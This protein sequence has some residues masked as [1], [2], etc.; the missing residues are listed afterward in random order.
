MSKRNYSVLVNFGMPW[1]IR[2]RLTT[3]KCRK[4]DK[5]GLPEYRG[6][7]YLPVFTGDKLKA[8]KIAQVLRVVNEL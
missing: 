6:V 2:C 1:K 5:F 3:A 7:K 8:Q 4:P